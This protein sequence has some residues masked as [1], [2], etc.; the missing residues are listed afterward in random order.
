MIIQRPEACDDPKMSGSV[1]V[2]YSPLILCALC[3]SVWGHSSFTIFLY[4]SSLEIL[5]AS[6][7]LQTDSAKKNTWLSCYRDRQLALLPAVQKEI[8]VVV[9]FCTHEPSLIC[10][11]RD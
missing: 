8:R 4:P 5:S 10:P 11:K 2:S 1:A 7:Y 3:H 9:Y 6:V